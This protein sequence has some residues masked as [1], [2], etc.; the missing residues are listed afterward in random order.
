GQHGGISPE[1]LMVP[2]VRFGAFV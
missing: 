2:L 1:E